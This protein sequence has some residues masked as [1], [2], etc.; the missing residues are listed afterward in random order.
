MM[1]DRQALHAYGVTPLFVLLWSSGAI[2]SEWGL[3][4]ASPF[5]FLTL[6]FVLAL[7][8]LLVI[9]AWRR[10]WLPTRGT[11]ARV[12]AVGALLT[13]SYPICYLLALSH[14]VTPGVL[15]TVLGVQP[16]LTLVSMERRFSVRR[17]AGLALALAGLVLVVGHGVAET[18]VPVLGMAF[19]LASLTTMTLGAIVQKG[20]A[21]APVDVLPLQYG[22]GLALCAVCLPFV[23]LHAEW[24]VGFLVPLAWLGLVISV[25]ATLLLY[26]LIQ[27]GNLVNVT[28]LFYLVPVV[29]AWLDNLV[30]GHRLSTSA[31]A[32]MGA[33]LA[34][35]ALV[36]SLGGLRGLRGS[37]TRRSD[38][39]K[40]TQ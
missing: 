8:V 3:A 23:P 33:I 26:R 32:G 35:L 9:A 38:Q 6:R 14:G 36:F 4:H 2:F 7:A 29:T 16:I 10:R 28:S 30:F 21:Q 13:G 15:A 11:R 34:G 37:R 39:A 20:V 1:I 5:A 18:H 22:V 27:A 40:R 31:L 12:V 25:V 19:A 17:M 24:T